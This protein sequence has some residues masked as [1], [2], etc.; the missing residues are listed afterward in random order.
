MSDLNLCQFIGRLGKDPEIR[1][2]QSGSAVASFSLAV[3]HKYKDKEHTE[4]VN[5][6]VFGKLAE[7]CGQYLTK[8][9]QV[10]IAGRMQTEKWQDKNG[11]DR[12]TT[13]IICNQMQILG[14]KSDQTGEQPKNQHQQ[15]KANGYQPQDD[16][17][18]DIPW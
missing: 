10:Y 3:G 8:G 18:D 7:I 17:D 6:S 11:Q 4:W 13:K 2:T 14:S 12:Y 15:A 5:V 16:F 9:K 1:Y